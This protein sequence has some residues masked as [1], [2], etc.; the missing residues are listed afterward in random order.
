MTLNT[1]AVVTVLVVA[2]IVVA[3]I[4]Y[5]A[6]S[7][8]GGGGDDPSTG[9]GVTDCHLWVYGNV[10]G[11]D[12]IDQNDIDLLERIIAGE[13]EEV[14]I[15]AY[16]GYSATG[17]SQKISLADA[18]MDGV[19]D[20]KDVQYIRD[21]IS[22]MERYSAAVNNGTLDSFDEEFTLHYNNCDNVASTV[23]LPV[24]TLVSMYFSNS[25]IVRLL[26]AVDRVVATD[27]TTLAKPTLLPEFQG[28]QNLGDRKAVNSEAVLATG[29]DAYF[30]GSASTYSEYLEKDVGDS[31]DI[32]RLSA[33][34]DNNVMVGA[35]TLGYILG[36]TEKAYEYIDWCNE[37]IDLIAERTSGL[38]DRMTVI[39]PKGRV[40][41]SSTL[42]EGNG[43]GSGQFEINELAGA[44]DISDRFSA[45]S[46]Y[47]NYTQ[48]GI[49]S[50]D[51]D[52]IV[53]SGYC[54][55]E[56]DTDDVG[57]RV[58]D[59]IDKVYYTYDGATATSEGRVYF[60]ANELYTGPSNI[61]A[62]VYVATWLYPDLFDDLDGLQ[63][64]KEY[65]EKFCPGL[66]YYGLEAHIDQ[67]VYGPDST[68]E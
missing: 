41:D 25:E 54:G 37:Y 12:Y 18:N 10:N 65:I 14:L 61:V 1:K 62:M 42:L 22:Y 55:W 64:F 67:F 36:C 5:Y 19:L 34:E 38:T 47:P 40:S 35:L 60:I 29:A 11:D 24:K 6:L 49:L 63:V 59:V 43:R 20:E 48:E 28:L 57:L 39:S 51:V 7:S 56:Y 68:R 58:H 66:S 17:V 31:V 46:E 32:I 15:V 16:D 50:Y 52:A 53:I 45:T 4:G 9:D 8:G 26:G 3:G 44:D 21:T 13:A 2:V 33:W 30:T 27:D 23:H